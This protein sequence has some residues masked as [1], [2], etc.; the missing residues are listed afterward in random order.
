MKGLSHLSI[1]MFSLLMAKPDTSSGGV[2]HNGTMMPNT[3]TPKEPT[4][5]PLYGEP[6]ISL[7]ENASVSEKYGAKST[8]MLNVII[9]IVSI[10]ATVETT[11]WARLQ[12]KSDGQVIEPSVGKPKG[13]KFT[14][15]EAKAAFDTAIADS[16]T[17][18]E[19]HYTKAF[20]AACDRLLNGVPKT[21]INGKANPLAPRLVKVAAKTSGPTAAPATA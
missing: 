15:S 16:L 11:I 12:N 2:I 5:V 1:V 8:A 7:P 6:I 10:G 17:A 13:M 14:S 3:D 19:P 4:A 18:W 9:P 21:G 20:D